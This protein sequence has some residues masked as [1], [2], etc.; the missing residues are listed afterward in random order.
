MRN[1]GAIAPFC[2]VLALAAGVTNPAQSADPYPSWHG[3]PYQANY[4]QPPKSRRPAPPPTYV[5]QTD[6]W[7]G[8]YFGGLVGYGFGTVDVSGT[9]GPLSFDHNGGMLGLYA[10]YNLRS[11]NWVYGIE[12]E[13][14]ASNLHGSSTSFGVNSTMDLN[15]MG[16]VRGRAGY[17]VAPALLVYGMAGVAWTN[18]DIRASVPLALTTATNSSLGWQ[19]GVGAE[20]KLTEQWSM[21]LDYLYTD[22]GNTKVVGPGLSN[23][24]A[25]DVQTLQLGLTYRF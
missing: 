3:Y 21:R 20:M 17:L 8:L 24:Y 15:W 2:L 10:G 5:Q 16:S 11:W 19:V 18:Y 12:G 6:Y 14:K 7:S 9:S 23:T 13:L 22:I 25:P 4:S 1:C